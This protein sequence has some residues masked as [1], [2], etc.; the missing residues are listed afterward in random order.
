MT[1][2]TFIE[3]IPCIADTH[4]ARS[5]IWGP[6]YVRVFVVFFDCFGYSGRLTRL[7]SV[8]VCVCVCVY[9][10]VCVCVCVC[11]CVHACCSIYVKL[12]FLCDLLCSN[13]IDLLG[14][15]IIFNDHGVPFT[16]ADGERMCFNATVVDDNE[17]ENLEYFYFRSYLLDPA[18]IEPVSTPET[19]IIVITVLDNEPRTYLEAT[20]TPFL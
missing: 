16:L 9:V 20:I 5:V 19:D 6:I 15:D 7:V 8:C 3:R 13:N 11:A 14:N 17:N 12:I 1:L 18:P 10:C 2:V 4:S